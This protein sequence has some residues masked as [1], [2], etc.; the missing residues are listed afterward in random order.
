[1]KTLVDLSTDCSKNTH[2]LMRD[3]YVI[4]SESI[5]S[6]TGAVIPQEIGKVV[7]DTSTGCIIKTLSGKV[8]SV[9]YSMI[10]FVKLTPDIVMKLGL[11]KIDD[12]M[13]RL[14]ASDDSCIIVEFERDREPIVYVRNGRYY[15]CPCCEFLHQ[16]QHALM[17]C[18]ICLNS[19]LFMFGN[20][21]I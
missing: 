17:T 9:N 11:Q 20:E 7:L 18:N 19:D 2:C 16:F 6:I 10:G 13:Y 1:M 4:V 12:K 14:S 3:D 21:C 5:D 8:V 15:A